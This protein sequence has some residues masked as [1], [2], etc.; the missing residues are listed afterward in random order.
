MGMDLSAFRIGEKECTGLEDE[1]EGEFVGKDAAVD[2]HS[3]VE[4]KG[5]E[6]MLGAASVGT[7]EGVPDEGIGVIDGMIE[8]ASS[9]G[10]V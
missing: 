8:K 1:R 5:I 4:N 6:L 10:K 7:D 3:T 2:Q 9:I